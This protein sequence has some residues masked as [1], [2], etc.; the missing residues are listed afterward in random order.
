M[1]FSSCGQYLYHLL[2]LIADD[3]ERG[4]TCQVFLS[5]FP[6]VDLESSEN[7][8]TSLQPCYETQH[9]TYNFWAQ[10]NM[11]KAPYILSYWDA[12]TALYLCLPLLS[13]NPKVVRFNL[14]GLVKETNIQTLAN[15]IFFPNSTP[16]RSPRILYRSSLKEKKDI[17][18]LALSGLSLEANETNGGYSPAVLEWKVNKKDGWRAWNETI[19]SSEPEPAEFRTYTEL[20]GT[21]IDADR[22][23]NVTVRSG[24]DWK[25]KAFLSCA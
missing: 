21:F 6:S 22:R 16:C 7:S 12:D 11:L 25:R 9:L 24:L 20:R 3:G 23:F 1:R 19:D 18:V 15:P 4:S 10:T 5:V 17:L 13:S 14:Q 8:G 2:V